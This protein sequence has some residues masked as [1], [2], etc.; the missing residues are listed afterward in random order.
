MQ[1]AK[2][3]K[4]FKD[5][6]DSLPPIPESP[7]GP[8]KRRL[9]L[10]GPK[11]A[12]DA[13]RPKKA[14][15]PSDSSDDEVQFEEKIERS[16]KGGGKL[17]KGGKHKR[18]TDS[19]EV[20]LEDEKNLLA[21]KESDEF[22]ASAIAG[23]GVERSTRLKGAAGLKRAGEDELAG[24]LASFEKN[25]PGARG[26]ETAEEKEGQGEEDESEDEDEFEKRYAG[27]P[28]T[29]EEARLG[30]GNFGALVSGDVSP[31]SGP[32]SGRS[33]ASARASDGSLR[34]FEPP[35]LPVGPGLKR[36]RSTAD[37]LRRRASG[38]L[39]EGPKQQ[40]S[41]VI[42]LTLGVCFYLDMEASTGLS[43]QNRYG[44]LTVF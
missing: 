40:V 1:L 22:D 41:F 42:R 36:K 28:V 20:S 7:R 44:V 14:S 3:I 11:A 29:A 38:S 10:E 39:S 35:A 8:I 25:K 23:R 24:L 33:D 6:V 4:V 16:G 30:S 13:K 37:L 32:V 2:Q 31:E 17:G 5:A 15:L 43:L 27:I 34:S 9:K 21:S 12:E 18:G 26:L 19:L